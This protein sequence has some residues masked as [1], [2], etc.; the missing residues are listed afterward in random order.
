MVYQDSPLTVATKG[1]VAGIVGTAAITVAMQNGPTLLQRLGLIDPPPNQAGGE[2]T[3]VLAE[4][5]SEGVLDQPIGERTQAV[6]GQAIR[7]SYGSGWGALY[8]IVQASLRPPHWLHGTILGVVTASVAS[9]FLPA[10]QLA[11]PPTKQPVAISASQFAYH[12][13]YGWVTATVYRLLA[14]E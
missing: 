8:G 4:K 1:A 5:V 14:K 11:P 10:M 12:L 7:W 3:E 9:T 13:L 6:A 2:P